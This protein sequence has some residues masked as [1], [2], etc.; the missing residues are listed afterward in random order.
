MPRSS[1]SSASATQPA[2][3][4]SSTAAGVLGS[5]DLITAGTAD[6]GIAREHRRRQRLRTVALL[7]A[8]PAAFLWYRLLHG[9]PFNVFALPHIDPLLLFAMLIPVTIIAA[10][11]VPQVAMGRSPHITY[12]PEQLDVRLDDVV[13][14]EQVK[15][16]V[17]R[18]LNLFLAHQT[19]A[20]EMGGR[21]RRG[22]LFEGPP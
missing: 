8:A 7:L 20:D 10:V 22:L 12:Q 2:L 17:V 15:E 9:D 21:P 3:I 14:V 1:A 6:V 4:T 11:V 16:E 18:S 5:S 19:F 13:G